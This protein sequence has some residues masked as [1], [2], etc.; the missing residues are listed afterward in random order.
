VL[1]CHACGQENPAGF[2]FCG[3]CGAA[4]EVEPGREERKIVTALFADIVGSTASAEQ[5]DPEDVRARLAPY[6]ARV[7][8]ELERF[9]GTVEKFI[10][11]AVVALFGAPAAHEDDPERAVRAAFAV[12]DAIADLNAADAWLDLHIRIGVNTGEA[13]V[14]LGAKATE[15]EGMAAGDVMN[16]AARLQSAAPVD[17]IIVS[18][19]TYEATAD[20]IEYRA[21]EPVQAKGKSEPL[22][23]WEAV[24]ARQ[25]PTRRAPSR[26]PLV[27]REAELAALAEL[28]T[29]V[30]ADRRPGLATVLG[31]PGIGKSR[32]L[33]EFAGRAEGAAV[34][35]GRCL[36]YGEG[37]TYWPIT[38]ILKGAAGILVDDEERVI[39]A[40]LGALLEGV[41]TDDADELRTMAAALA[42]L[43]G[44]PTTPL[45]TYSAGEITQAELH[46]GIRRVLQLLAARNPLVLVF[47]D[48]HWA[49][50]TLLELL[51]SIVVTT[52]GA[53]LLLVGSARPELAEAHPAM[54]AENERR[55]VLELEALSGDDSQALLAEL[56]ESEGVPR[57]RLDALLEAAGGNPLFLEETVRMLVDAGTLDA[58]EGELAARVQELAVPRS[59]QAL[60]GS[61]LDQLDASTKR[62]A[63]NASVVGAVFWPGAVAHLNGTEGDLDR[64][65]EA[66]ARRDFI[67][68]HEIS[69]VAGELEYAFKHV[70]IRDVAYGQVPKGRRV[71]LHVRF[72]DWVEALPAG[73]EEF[74]EIVAYH[75]EQ[76]CRLAREVARSPIPP[77]VLRAADLLARAAEKAERREGIREAARFYERAL[78]V[79]GDEFPE[80]ATELRLRRGR[81]RTALG[82]LRK[83]QSE[84]LDVAEQAL[85]LRRSDLRCGALIALAVIDQ[86]QGRFAEARRRLTEAHSIAV[87]IEDRVLQIRAGYELG[88][89]SGDFEGDLDAALDEL[90][91]ALA[92]AEK[93]DES[94]L[95][96][97]GHLR[98]GTVLFN[99]G[100]LIQAEE[101]LLRCIA[102]A[103][104]LGSHRD[105]A[106]STFMLGG[107]RYYRAG[108][109]EAERLAL[110][111]RDW[112]ARTCE[113]TY[114][115]QNLRQLG[116]YALVRGDPG[117]AEEWLREALEAALELGGWQVIDAYRY[118]VE[119]LVAQERL[120]DA[121][122]LAEFAG[123]NVSGEDP[124]VRATVLLAEASVAAAERDRTGATKRFREALRLL[125]EER[126]PL[127]RAE[128]RMDLAH[129]LRR[130]GDLDGA[131]AELEET[132]ATFD[133]MGAHGLVAQIDRELSELASEAGVAGPTRP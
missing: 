54:V 16:T 89:L 6:Y 85:A 133:R 49:E 17:G 87:A 11:D 42:N 66:L 19:P 60:I 43:M 73:E 132:R 125:E 96:V 78:D 93:L 15:G 1:T 45:G 109:E 116:L 9:G 7:R 100:E 30:L 105:E 56:L 68:A 12:R 55:R 67:R 65:L 14:V 10:G 51:L 70:L 119:A 84:L 110:Q 62:I 94:E 112:L 24:T 115:I 47:E 79:V 91:G 29:R 32:L 86:E 4:L 22:A 90:Q 3:A 59:L 61:R 102:L 108:I 76:S 80:T 40:K 35:W 88:T 111:A 113:S 75:L 50:P 77:P 46:W 121:R 95:R 72:A 92:I 8:S 98:M 124:Y 117:R 58:P 39:S 2:H 31:P 64:G 38:E 114:Q 118:L 81:M 127:V 44:V 71:E 26:V 25:V 99:G 74:V 21:A 33:V 104:Q 13:L 18:E 57:G 53:P 123:R 120:D 37:I 63:Q 106:R 122:Q 82:E 97:E 52:E 23:V 103:E 41:E 128:A 5:L 20:A 69:T 101:H 27:G 28:W 34:H 130:F 131:R 129:A 36:S 48:L 83:A 107:V 126:S